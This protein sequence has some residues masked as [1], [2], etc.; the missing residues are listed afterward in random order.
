MP[1]FPIV[2]KRFTP[3]AFADYAAHVPLG[4]WKPN[5]V[6]LH[7][8]AIPS[9]KQRPNGFSEAN[10][11]DLRH[12]YGEVQNWKGGPHL[13]VDHVG[14]W[15]FN[16]LDRRGTHSPS[17]NARSWGVEMLGDFAVEPFDTGNG[18]RVQNHAVSALAALFRRLEIAQI[19]NANFKLHKEDPKTDHDCPGK[20]VDKAKVRVAVQALLTAAPT[21]VWPE[22]PARIVVYRRGGGQSPTAIVEAVLRNGT[23]YADAEELS[24]ATGIATAEDGEVGLRAFVGAKYAI[25]WKPETHRVYLVEN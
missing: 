6:V 23:V 8:T 12:Y 1:L 17:W 13:F 14:I 16:P 2:G 24:E 18:L 22:F 5:L 25:T 3:S 4:D 15:V 9:L 10:I 20:H 7:N 19:T 21:G 11:E